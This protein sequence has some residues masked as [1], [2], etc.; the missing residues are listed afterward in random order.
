MN[1]EAKWVIKIRVGWDGR[2]SLTRLIGW[3]GRYSLTRLNVLTF[4]ITLSLQIIL[5]LITE[6]L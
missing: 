2:Y 4:M 3:D 5:Y 6:T 1:E